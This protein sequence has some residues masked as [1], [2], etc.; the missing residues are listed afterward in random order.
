MSP[1]D[2]KG[3]PLAGNQEGGPDARSA[4]ITTSRITDGDGI[5]PWQLRGARFVPREEAG[6]RGPMRV[7]P[8]AFTAAGL[9][10]PPDPRQWN[11]YQLSG[12]RG[13]AW[14]ASIDRHTACRGSEIQ[15]GGLVCVDADTA[16][17]IDGHVW[18]DGFRRLADL[19]AESGEVLDLSGCVAVRTPGNGSHGQGWHL[20][21]RRGD[22]PVQPGPLPREPLVEIK[23][24]CTAPGSPGYRV[25]AAADGDR[26][27]LPGWLAALAAVPRPVPAGGG[28]RGKGN[29]RARLEGVLDHLLS[30]R[31]G[32][33]RNSGLYW[34]SCRCGEMI[35]AGELESAAAEAAL[36]RAAEENGHAGKHGAAATLGTIRSG[37]SA[38]MRQAV[39]A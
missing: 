10:V 23:F 6:R 39:A 38:G 35:A 29:P 14:S 30:L 20:W 7:T 19:G 31:A 16:L 24:R 13:F 18:R 32:D 28:Q 25:R 4:A 17:A 21:F 8:G 12:R 5:V 3:R 11:A 37:I 34:C 15:P 9:P 22:S 2:V 27:V 36:F 33:H 26:D 1:P